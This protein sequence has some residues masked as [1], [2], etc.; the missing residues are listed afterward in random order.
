LV[1]GTWYLVPN[2]PEK[3]LLRLFAKYQLPSTKYLVP[4]MPES[5]KLRIPTVANK[6]PSSGYD[7]S[8][9][10]DHSRHGTMPLTTAAPMALV[11]ISMANGGGKPGAGGRVTGGGAGMTSG[12]VISY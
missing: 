12:F 10:V 1:F 2:A 5:L 4:I 9:V 7:V 11:G 6:M 3:P 8:P